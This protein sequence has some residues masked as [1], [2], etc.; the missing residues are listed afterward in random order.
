MGSMQYAENMVQSEKAACYHVLQDQRDGFEQAARM[1]ELQASQDQLRAEH[2]ASLR[3]HG[4]YQ[5]AIVD[6]RK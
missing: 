1:F 3:V 4:E 2:L 5:D 6:T